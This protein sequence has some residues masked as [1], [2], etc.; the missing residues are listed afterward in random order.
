[1]K[2]H[3]QMA[4][5]L[6]P[7][8]VKCVS[9]LCPPTLQHVPVMSTVPKK[10]RGSSEPRPA[11]SASTAPVAIPRSSSVSCHAH[12]GSKKHKRTPL[13]QRSVRGCALKSAADAVELTA[14]F[15]V[16]DVSRWAETHCSWSVKEQFCGFNCIQ[17]SFVCW[18]LHVTELC[19]RYFAFETNHG[20][21][22][23]LLFY[24]CLYL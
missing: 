20:L 1:M 4:V 12:P 11:H 15:C 5:S 21:K 23:Q 22:K 3:F 9:K 16:E 19:C 6:N 18:A 24:L 8:L 14:W 2:L 7:P 17:L 13:Y 10:E